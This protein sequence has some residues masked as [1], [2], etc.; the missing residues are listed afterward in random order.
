MAGVPAICSDA[1]GA[2]VAVRASGYGGV[3]ASLDQT[4]LI[5]LLQHESQCGRP[6]LGDRQALSAWAACLGAETGA[7]YLLKIFDHVEQRGARP[8]PPWT[9][10]H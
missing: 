2:S 3:F 9:E 1:C 7:D 5:A 6:S 8:A 10:A 4:G